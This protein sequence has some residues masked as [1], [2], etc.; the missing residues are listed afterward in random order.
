MIKSVGMQPM[1]GMR[2]NQEVREWYVTAA[3]RIRDA[4]PANLPMDQR[5]RMAFDMRNELR[6]YARDHMADTGTRGRL[7]AQHPNLDFDAFVRKKM[8]G[9]KLTYEEA[10]ADI[11][12][13]ATKTNEDVNA[14]FGIG[15]N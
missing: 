11:F 3:S 12:A 6:T 8:G 4:I 5:A 14:L 10:L 7:D 13:T 1:D 9:K 15:T 2:S